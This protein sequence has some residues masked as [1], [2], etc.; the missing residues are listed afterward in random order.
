MPRFRAMRPVRT[1][2]GDH[3]LA[4]V[5]ED[6]AS[7]VALLTADEVNILHRGRAERVPKDQSLSIVEKGCSTNPNVAA[8]NNSR[9]RFGNGTRSRL[10]PRTPILLLRGRVRLTTSYSSS[11]LVKWNGCL[12]RILRRTK[13]SPGGERKGKGPGQEGEPLALSSS[14]ARFSCCRNASFQEMGQAV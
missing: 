3:L 5:D 13:R 9:L 8:R 10:G 2:F 7:A 14:R 4:A 12:A 11:L 6:S 1:E